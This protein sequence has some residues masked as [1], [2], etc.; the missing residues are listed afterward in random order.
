MDRSCKRLRSSIPHTRMNRRRT[1]QIHRSSMLPCLYNRG[2]PTHHKY[3]HRLHH[4]CSFHHS[5]KQILVT[6]RHSHMP[7]L[8]F[9][10]LHKHR[11]H[12]FLGRNR[13]PQLQPHCSCMLNRRCNQQPQIHHTYRHRPHHS[14]SCHRNRNPHQDIHKSRCR[15]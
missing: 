4:C 9:L 12:L 11:I 1:L 3:R 13:L 2:T 5:H 15:L 7:L 14:S 8:G 6:F 10:L